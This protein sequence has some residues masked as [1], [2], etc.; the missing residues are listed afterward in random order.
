MPR[1]STIAVVVCAALVLII[2]TRGAH[3]GRT[4][5]LVSALEVETGTLATVAALGRASDCVHA[6]LASGGVGWLTGNVWFR[7]GERWVVAA[8]DLGLGAATAVAEVSPRR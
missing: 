6:V 5:G 8:T 3:Q 7:A 2:V 4:A 1:G